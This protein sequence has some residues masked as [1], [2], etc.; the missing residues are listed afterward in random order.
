MRV[1]KS[2]PG[3]YKTKQTLYHLTVSVSNNERYRLNSPE[4]FQLV[5][6]CGM[7]KTRG[8]DI[9]L[10]PTPEK[11]ALLRAWSGDDETGSV[12]RNQESV[13]GPEPV[14]PRGKMPPRVRNRSFID[15]EMDNDNDIREADSIEN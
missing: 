1:R 10:Q 9:Q 14:V 15:D 6:Y 13:A 3:G 5:P 2:V 12:P 11:G 4:C 8:Y 7:L